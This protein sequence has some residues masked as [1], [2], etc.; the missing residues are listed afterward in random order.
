[1]NRRGFFM[2]AIA[3]PF[4]SNLKPKAVG[5]HQL[6]YASQPIVIDPSAP[7]SS[8]F[9]LIEK[10]IAAAYMTMSGMSHRDIFMNGQAACTPKQ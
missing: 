3:A 6:K 1:M 4:L 2:A 10:R 5:F 9:Q 8:A 7:S